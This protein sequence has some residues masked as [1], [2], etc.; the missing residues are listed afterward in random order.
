M[1]SLFSNR[2]MILRDNGDGGGGA[3]AGNGNGEP[4]KGS[5][6][7][8]PEFE[9]FASFLAKQPKEVRDLYDQDVQGLKSTVTATRSERDNLAAQ[10]KELTKQAGKGTELE[11]QLT[12]LS[13]SLEEA[14]RKAD[15]MAEAPGMECKNAKAAYALML[16]DKLY[17]KKGNPDWT[18]IKAA[19]PELFG[20]KISKTN[21]GDGAGDPP[22]AGGMNAWIRNQAKH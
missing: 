9:D 21:A 17:D 12:Q 16:A 18:A 2:P 15:F 19:A 20:K 1:L 3:G 4:G 14:N 8:K 5:E 11:T 10:I 13:A 7:G 6:G 22:A